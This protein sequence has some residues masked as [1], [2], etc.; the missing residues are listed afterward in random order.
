[1]T[2]DTVRIERYLW[3]EEEHLLCI[4]FAYYAPN[5]NMYNM[6]SDPLLREI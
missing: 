1:M 5:I 6:F 3:E 2:S 4:I